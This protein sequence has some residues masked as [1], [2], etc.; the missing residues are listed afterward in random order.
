MSQDP[1]QLERMLARLDHLAHAWSTG[2]PVRVN[3]LARVIAEVQALA[4]TCRGADLAALS[5]RVAALSAAVGKGRA[6][7][8]SELAAIPA[9]RRAVRAHA[10]PPPVETG[11]RLRRRA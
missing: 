3:E 2:T 11:T 1:T 8:E 6:R 7:A 4:A 10:P 9:R 5:G